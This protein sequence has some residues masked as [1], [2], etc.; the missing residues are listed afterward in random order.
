[1][2]EEIRNK[3]HFVFAERVDEVFAAALRLNDNVQDGKPQ[4]QTQEPTTDGSPASD[5]EVKKAQD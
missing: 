2:P 3:M 5:E 4:L 1:V